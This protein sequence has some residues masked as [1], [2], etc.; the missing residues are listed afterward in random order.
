MFL[1]YASDHKDSFD[2][3][4]AGIA[5]EWNAHN[6]AYYWYT[7]VNKDITQ[8][9]RAYDADVGSTLFSED[10]IEVKLASTVQMSPVLLIYDY[11]K[12]V[13]SKGEDYE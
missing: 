5:A 1:R 6:A 2:G 4:A 8:A 3:S 7:Y 11:V 10:N 12:Y 13:R 9:D